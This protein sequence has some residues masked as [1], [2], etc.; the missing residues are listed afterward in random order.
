MVSAGVAR[1]L[2]NTLHALK[3]GRKHHQIVK[4]DKNLR[5]PFH[6]AGR[7]IRI[8]EEALQTVR[9][10]VDECD[11]A[12]T[13][14]NAMIPLE[15]CNTKAQLFG[16][17]FQD[18]AQ[19]PEAERFEH[20]KAAVQQQGNGQTVEALALEIMEDVCDL[21]ENDTIK[22]EMEHHIGI[23]REEIIKL[24]EMGSSVSNQ[25]SGNTFNTHGNSRQFNAFGGTQYNNS[26]SGHQFSGATFSGPVNFA[27][28]L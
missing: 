19:A 28:I 24:S 18:V 14:Q 17:I 12:E 20:Y 7:A 25:R 16:R 27:K 23:L 1:L 3:A 21:A 26:G 22:T 6:E 5:E 15:A 2:S 9:T 11:L 8:V 13:P 4:D 10:E